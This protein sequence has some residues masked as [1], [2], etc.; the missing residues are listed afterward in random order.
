MN[1]LEVCEVCGSQDFQTVTQCAICDLHVDIDTNKIMFYVVDQIIDTLK[2]GINNKDLQVLIVS[3]EEVLSSLQVVKNVLNDP[4][5]LQKWRDLEDRYV[6]KVIKQL[7]HRLPGSTRDGSVF[8]SKKV[9]E[10]LKALEEQI[11]NFE[12]GD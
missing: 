12:K 5:N 8:I 11:N 1:K 9:R 6:P 7:G 3:V 4:N 10:T 2:A